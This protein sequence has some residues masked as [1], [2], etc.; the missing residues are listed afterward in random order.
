MS[1]I[2][3]SAEWWIRKEFPRSMAKR[4][5]NYSFKQRRE[6]WLSR[7]NTSVSEAMSDVFI[8][9]E[10]EEGGYYWRNLRNELRIKGK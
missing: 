4:I 9:D 2:T 3:N 7:Q 1:V 8:W 6:S 5:I 10:T